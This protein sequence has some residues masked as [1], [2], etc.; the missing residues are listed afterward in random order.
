MNKKIVIAI[1]VLILVLLFVSVITGTIAYYN[2]KIA[3]L[4]NQIS[5]FK[6]QIENL[7]SANLTAE[8][9]ITEI[10]YQTHFLNGT[11]IPDYYPQRFSN[12]FINGSVTN[13]GEGIAFNAG[14]HVSAY[15]NNVTLAVNM[16]VPL[17]N[18]GWVF[19]TDATTNAFI[20]NYYKDNLGTLQ[21]GYLK[22][23]QTVAFDLSFYHEVNIFNWTLTPVWANTP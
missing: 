5:S 3:N 7:T 15:T 1:S 18:G 21:L 13:Q 2:N 4:N 6:T 20:S 14:L 23:G 9:T 8:L 16:T 22:S 12:L 11:I 10:P 19:G 17:V